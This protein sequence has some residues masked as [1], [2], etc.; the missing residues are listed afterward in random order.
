MRVLCL[1]LSYHKPVLHS[2][3]LIYLILRVVENGF[4]RFGLVFATPHPH[5]NSDEL[6]GLRCQHYGF[7]GLLHLAICCHSSTQ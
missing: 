4:V 2:T 7:Q 3:Q 6:G 5:P 1:R